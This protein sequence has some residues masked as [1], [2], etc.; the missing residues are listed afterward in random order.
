MSRGRSKEDGARSTGPGRA[1]EPRALRRTLGLPL[2]WRVSLI[3]A[4]L[5]VA[6]AV[7]LALSPATVSSELVVREAVVLGFGVLLVLGLNL[8]LVRRTLDPLERLMRLM[9]QVDLLRPGERL[10]VAGE[11]AKWRSSPRRSMPWSSGWQV[12]VARASARDRSTG[13]G[14]SAFGA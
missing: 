8:A 4:I 1:D 3:N 10:P 13:A 6:A 2:F 7:G 12:S 9:R 14:A 5:L 11:G